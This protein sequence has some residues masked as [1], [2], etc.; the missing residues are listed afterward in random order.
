[1]PQNRFYEEGE[2]Q[3]KPGE[4]RFV[5]G[6]DMVKRLEDL[7][8]DLLG[9]FT[10]YMRV[11]TSKFQELE[12]EEAERVVQSDGEHLYLGRRTI[13]DPKKL[14]MLDI[15]VYTGRI[16]ALD[17]AIQIKIFSEERKDDEISKKLRFRFGNKY[18]VDPEA[19]LQYMNAFI[20]AGISPEEV[21]DK[22]A[23]SVDEIKANPK[24]YAP[25]PE[26][27]TEYLAGCVEQIRQIVENH[28]F[29]KETFAI[30]YLP[31]ELLAEKLTLLSPELSE[32]EKEKMKHYDSMDDEEIDAIEKGAQQCHKYYCQLFEI[33][34]KL[35]NEILG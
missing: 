5:E 10:K 18:R 29:T 22:I 32:E 1:M 27:A 23:E 11:D 3:K 30:V 25:E 7:L 4:P 24:K 2:F 26:K 8:A 34:Q 12:T 16:Q 35:A 15:G 21:E 6:I 31:L 33:Y 14:S 19:A 28:R 9:K 13:K 17:W 20:K